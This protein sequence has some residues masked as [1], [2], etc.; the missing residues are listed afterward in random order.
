MCCGLPHEKNLPPGACWSRRVRDTQGLQP[1]PVGH[2]TYIGQS[3]ASL[4]P[5][6]QEIIADCCEPLSS[7]VFVMQHIMCELTDTGLMNGE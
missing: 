5:C 4:Q 1:S 3:L 6:K 2:P 7:V